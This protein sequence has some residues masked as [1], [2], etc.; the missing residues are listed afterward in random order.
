MKRYEVR[1]LGEKLGEKHYGVFDNDKKEFIRDCNGAL[2][3][4]FVSE[5]VAWK[6]AGE[7]N[8]KK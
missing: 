7:L 1:L 8:E 5:E 4:A 6:F 3:R 2:I